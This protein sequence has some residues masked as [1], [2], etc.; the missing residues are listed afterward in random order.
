MQLAFVYNQDRCIGCNGCVIACKDWNQVNPG[1]ASWRNLT[2]KESGV[3]PTLGV[4]NLVMACNHCENPVCAA[5]CPV[6]A[7]VKR[8]E[9]GIV[10]VDRNRCQLFRTCVARCPFGAPQFG[11]DSNEP[12]RDPKW[13][14]DHP[15]QKCTFCADRW[16]IG[17]KPSC[18]ESCPQ[19]ALDA[20]PMEE[21]M[22]KYPNAQRAV[23]GFP[24]SARD[25]QGNPLKEDT[26]PSILFIPKSS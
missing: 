5:V 1:P 4:F 20:G 2:V 19:R 14:V 7:I 26:V 3:F 17:K 18:V 22:Q 10:L 8:E 23:L 24:D 13:A 9:D 6:G 21:M 25:P 16:A 11:D 15:M 12:V